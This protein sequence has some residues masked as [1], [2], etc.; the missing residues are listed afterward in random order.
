[1]AV[2]EEKKRFYSVEANTTLAFSE[3]FAGKKEIGEGRTKSELP[4]FTLNAVVL[5]TDNFSPQNKL[6]EG[7]FG[8]V[9]KVFF[10]LIDINADKEKLFLVANEF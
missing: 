6:G 4:F 5:A 10:T 1:M 3:D 7:G 8:S 2:R 9:Y